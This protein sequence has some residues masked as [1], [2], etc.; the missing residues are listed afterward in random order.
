MKNKRHEKILEIINI[1]P[2]FTQ[3]DLQNELLNYGYN[4]TQSTV[5]RDIR[6]LKLFKGHDSNGNYCYVSPEARAEDNNAGLKKFMLQSV[7][8]VDYALNDVVIKCQ[9]GMAQSVCVAVE[10]EFSDIMLGSVAGDDTVLVI[11]KSEAE[12]ANF[13]KK[14][15]KLL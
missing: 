12:A 6:E 4:V 9:T 15:K 1:K 7:L 8:S 10:S 14:I 3:D 13:V 5:S 11:T 2:I